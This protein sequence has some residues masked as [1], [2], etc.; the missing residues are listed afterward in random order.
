MEL[1]G[2]DLWPL[3]RSCYQNLLLLELMTQ[4]NFLFLPWHPGDCTMV[5]LPQPGYWWWIQPGYGWWAV[6]VLV[7]LWDLLGTRSIPTAR[8]TD[9]RRCHWWLKPEQLSRGFGVGQV[10]ILIL[11]SKTTRWRKRASEH[12]A[13]GG[14]ALLR[15]TCY[16]WQM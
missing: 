13:W 4:L 1:Q 16:S 15:G 2:A 9:E 11:Y 14:E 7:L 3:A 5:F 6:R 8:R 12:S 10:C